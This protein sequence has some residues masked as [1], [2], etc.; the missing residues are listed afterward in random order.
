MLPKA[1]EQLVLDIAECLDNRRKK[2]F[3]YTDARNKKRAQGDPVALLVSL[4]QRIKETLPEGSITLHTPVDWA[5]YDE[6]IE[7]AREL[8]EESEREPAAS[9]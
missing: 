7:K 2:A 3:G 8:I 5:F 6:H 1:V 4:L 9:H